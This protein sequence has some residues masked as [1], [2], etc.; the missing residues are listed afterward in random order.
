MKITVTIDIVGDKVSVKTDKSIK[1]GT[2][3]KVAEPTMVKTVEK[4]CMDC[5]SPFIAS[6][7]EIAKRK[8]CDSCRD[9]SKKRIVGIGNNKKACTKC[10]NEMPLTSLYKE[11]AN[12]RP[13]RVKPSKPPCKLCVKFGTRCKRHRDGPVKTTKPAAE[14]LPGHEKSAEELETIRRN[15]P[16]SMP[17]HN[18]QMAAAT[19]GPTEND[20]WDCALCREKGSR[21]R[22]H[23][24]MEEAGSEP[25][26][27]KLG[28]PTIRTN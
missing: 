25:P 15:Y 2:P 28:V 1:E 9:K 20:P 7:K 19:F 6:G 10:G 16:D 22:L 14:F 5:G 23:Y 12:C 3:R 4:I 18:P 26:K 17:K 13:V 8:R 24:K 27:R 11:C 21:C